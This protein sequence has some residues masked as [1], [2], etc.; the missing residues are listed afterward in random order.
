MTAIHFK[1]PGQNSGEVSKLVDLIPVIRRLLTFSPCGK[2]RNEAVG[3]TISQNNKSKLL[4]PDIVKFVSL[5]DKEFLGASISSMVKFGTRWSYSSNVSL[6]P[7]WIHKKF[8]TM[9][10]R[11][12]IQVRYQ[13]FNMPGSELQQRNVLCGSVDNDK[14]II[15]VCCHYDS[16]SERPSI[17]APGADD[18]ASGVA[19]TLELARLLKNVELKREVLYCVFGGEEQGLFG[20]D[21]CAEIAIQQNWPIDVVI[22][23]DM[24]SYKNPIGPSRIVVEYDQGNRDPRNDAA[25]KTYGLIMAQASKGLYIIGG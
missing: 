25:A 24:V 21:A 14:S 6:V 10:Y 15:L 5:V 19:A 7:E 23:L 13:D 16:L 22:N 20:S 1:G 9:G 8:V 11:E 2:K 17:E 18:N 3:R 12:N 4:N